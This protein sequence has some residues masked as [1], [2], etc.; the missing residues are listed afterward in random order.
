MGTE[1]KAA[2]CCLIDKK[3]VAAVFER[4]KKR[5]DAPNRLGRSYCH[6]MEYQYWD[7]LAW[8]GID[9][10]CDRQRWPYVM[11]ATAVSS[12]QFRRSGSLSLGRS[13]ALCYKNG[14]DC[15]AARKRLRQLTESNDLSEIGH[16][17]RLL[18][19]F[20]DKKVSQPLDFAKILSQLKS[21]SH[22]ERHIARAQ[23][24]QEFYGN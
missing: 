17:L 18:F 24:T 16:H 15:R 4:Q 5:G 12:S 19:S 22:G 9:V 10:S 11:I 1:P 7:L 13:I 20:I 21:I 2:E 23:W 3:F 6:A 8:F 14:R